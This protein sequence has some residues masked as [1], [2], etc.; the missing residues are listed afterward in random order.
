MRYTYK[1]LALELKTASNALK[2]SLKDFQ[3]ASFQR[4]NFNFSSLWR[5]VY[6]RK[7]VADVRIWREKAKLTLE[8]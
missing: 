4:A 2:T 1:L 5:S 6:A 3:D 7:D 8:L